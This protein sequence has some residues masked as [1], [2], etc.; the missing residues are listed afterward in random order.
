MVLTAGSRPAMVMA[1]AAT[2]SNVRIR[3]PTMTFPLQRAAMSARTIRA[4]WL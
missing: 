4:A 2:A 3:Q 1:E